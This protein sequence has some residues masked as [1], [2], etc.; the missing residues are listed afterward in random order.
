MFNG[1]LAMKIEE[2]IEQLARQS[3]MDLIPMNY[4]KLI[5]TNILNDET[6]ELIKDVIELNGKIT[7]RSELE[8]DVYEYDD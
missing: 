5:T 2:Q 4:D 1:G 6:E 7:L 3:M 8:I